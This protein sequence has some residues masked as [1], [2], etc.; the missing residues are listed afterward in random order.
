MKDIS[1][2]TS[3]TRLTKMNMV[4]MFDDAIIHMASGRQHSSRK[5]M[6]NLFEI[7][8]SEVVYVSTWRGDFEFHVNRAKEVLHAVWDDTLDEPLARVTRLL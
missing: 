3:T 8:L 6:R 7:S 1:R 2:Q 5:E 4:I